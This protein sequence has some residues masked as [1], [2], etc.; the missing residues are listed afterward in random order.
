VVHPPMKGSVVG[1]P[2]KVSGGLLDNTHQA[3]NSAIIPF[4]PQS[5]GFGILLLRI[6]LWMSPAARWH[7]ICWL[8]QGLLQ[9]SMDQIVYI[10]TAMDPSPASSSFLF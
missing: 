8:C 3:S 5:M 9:R 2:S 1:I 7:I 4:V 6:T 10:L